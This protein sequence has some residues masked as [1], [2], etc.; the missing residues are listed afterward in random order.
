[1]STSWRTL[2]HRHKACLLSGRT[3][4]D[5][6]ETEDWR[7]FS[8]GGWHIMHQRLHRALE[9][10]GITGYKQHRNSNTWT[11]DALEAGVPET[12]IVQMGG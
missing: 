8:E 11:R 9:R 7:G 12:A 6:R 5:D 3:L 1:M 10:R 4:E 2:L